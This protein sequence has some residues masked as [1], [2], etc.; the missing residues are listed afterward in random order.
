MAEALRDRCTRKI[1]ELR[2]KGLLSL[3]S[4][5]QRIPFIGDYI[6]SNIATT[7]HGAGHDAKST[8][9]QEVV[10][11]LRAPP[12]RPG[13][14]RSKLI[15]ARIGLLCQ[16]QRPN[17]CI[18]KENENDNTDF[19]YYNRDIN[20]GCIH[21]LPIALT[22]LL[23]DT[24]ANATL[25]NAVTAARTAAISRPVQAHRGFSPGARCACIA[26]EE[27]CDEDGDAPYGLCKW[28]AFGGPREQG[29]CLPSDPASAGS[30]EGLKP[31][32]G[33]KYTYRAADPPGQQIM[34]GTYVLRPGGIRWRRPASP[35][36]RSLARIELQRLMR[37][38]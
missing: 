29:L 37:A 30:F 11:F 12:P 26:T 4:D 9:I 1:N 3:N 15:Q 34:R 27:E 2:A 5:V 14:D 16:N 21:A 28:H 13:V 25:R 10:N 8:S 33:Q 38:L 17:A 31:F 6:S 32:T 18:L 23:P 36:G 20:R 19:R 22:Q 35:P 24:P 7:I